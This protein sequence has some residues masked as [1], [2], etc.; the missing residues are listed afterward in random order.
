MFEPK[1]TVKELRK[2]LDNI[3]K[4]YDDYFISA[5][6]DVTGLMELSLL[7]TDTFII[8]ERKLLYLKGSMIG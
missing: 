3:P 1:L 2:S 8:P 4:D 6:D 7:D 5:I